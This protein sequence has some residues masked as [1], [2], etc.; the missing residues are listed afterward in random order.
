MLHRFINRFQKLKA[1]KS[2]SDRTPNKAYLFNKK[3]YTYQSKR[4]KVKAMIE[5]EK[6]I[7]QCLH[8]K[9]PT[10]TLVYLFGSRA[11]GSNTIKSDYDVAILTSQPLDNYQRFTIAQELAIKLDCDVDLV[12]LRQASTV[13]KMQVA[14]TGR[15]L[16]GEKI[17]DD[18]FS[19]A[20]YS[21]YAHLQEQR[22]DVVNAYIQG[23]KDE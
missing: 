17:E 13:L 22:R 16:F 8:E 1:T 18:T 6:I 11:D 5:K 15:L 21:M 10:L 4:A 20:A 3:R 12:D 19:A 14:S 7:V 2:L 9:I 23:V